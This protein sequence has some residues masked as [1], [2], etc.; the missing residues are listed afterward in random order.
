M[1]YENATTKIRVCSRLSGGHGSDE[2]REDT[3]RHCIR[4]NQ[5]KYSKRDEPRG[6]LRSSMVRAI[7]GSNKQ[8]GGAVGREVC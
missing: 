1:T 4:A 8:S 5:A 3:K 7:I 6:L 2:Q